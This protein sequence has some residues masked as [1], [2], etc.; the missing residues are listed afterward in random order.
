MTAGF[1]IVTEARATV[2][3]STR[4]YRLGWVFAREVAALI[5]CGQPDPRLKWQSES[6]VR[7]LIG[8]ILPETVLVRKQTLERR[9]RRFWVALKEEMQRQG[10]Q[11]AGR[12]RYLEKGND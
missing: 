1:G 3:R 5:C 2:L 11:D 6:D 10:W 7:V 9:P 4:V 8:K 12:G